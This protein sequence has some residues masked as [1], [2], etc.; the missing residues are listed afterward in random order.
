MQLGKKTTG[1]KIIDLDTQ[2]EA[3]N[4]SNVYVW[5]KQTKD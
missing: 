3:Y 4:P 1:V 2:T 5:T